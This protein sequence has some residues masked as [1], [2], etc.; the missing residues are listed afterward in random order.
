[1]AI[2][3]DMVNWNSNQRADISEMR[4]HERNSRSDM[5][6]SIDNLLF[7][8]NAS[9]FNRVFGNFKVTASNPADAV[10]SVN[11]GVA[12]GAE[13]LDDQTNEHGVMFGRDGESSKALDFSSLGAATYNVWVRF[14][15]DP[16]EPGVRVFYNADTQ[17]EEAQ[18]VDTRLVHDWDVTISIVSPGDEWI[19][20]AEV[21]WGGATIAAG[22]ITPKRHM[23][24]EGDAGASYAHEWGDGAN[25]RD[26][27]RANNGVRAL[28]EHTH[29]VRRQIEEIFDDLLGTKWYEVPPSNLQEARDH[30]D[31]SSD[32]HGAILTQTQ[33]DLTTLTNVETL[34]IEN[35]G[36]DPAS[37]YF[38][39][40]ANELYQNRMLIA[41]TAAHGW[42]DWAMTL[43][44]DMPAASGKYAW[45]GIM[46]ATPGH[47]VAS[48]ININD[49]L[50]GARLS[51][52][53]EIEGITVY[54]YNDN[55][56]DTFD[57]IIN[58]VRISKTTFTRS[59]IFTDTTLSGTGAALLSY[60]VGAGTALDTN[61]YW[62]ELE[63]IIQSDGV[64]LS[65]DW[66][67]YG[68]AIQY[69]KS[70]FFG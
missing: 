63:V 17:Q 44:T 61:T 27:D 30:I 52:S 23:F 62:Y 36:G 5:R 3:R 53:A 54:Y 46:S 1:M 47:Q 57:I 68:V 43:S 18:T 32:P 24:F 4:A 16:G 11:A 56:P 28:Y 42:G 49:R 35:S 7:G 2:D 26:T 14:S 58:L 37:R 34:L 48:V 60:T 22:N 45:T 19:L 67:V 6:R 20:L 13:V 69:E 70:V 64:A 29:A 38:V 59:T 12:V 51:E 65:A 40:T 50:Y 55:A 25:D 41:D 33:L 8:S 66:G 39:I 31:D 9:G 21:V 10:V 15:N